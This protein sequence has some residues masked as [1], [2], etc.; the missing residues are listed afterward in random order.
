MEF[1]FL[2]LFEIVG[3]EAA[4]VDHGGILDFRFQSVDWRDSSVA[5]VLR[6]KKERT[7]LCRPISRIL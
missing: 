2:E 5:K 3:V 1:D 6:E 7:V 4:E